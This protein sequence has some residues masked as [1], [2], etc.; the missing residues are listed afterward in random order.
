M[1]SRKEV[2][3]KKDGRILFVIVDNEYIEIKCSKCGLKQ[4]Y[5]LPEKQLTDY[6][7]SGKIVLK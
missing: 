7:P 4:T 3:C 2:R 1:R 6:T 5:K